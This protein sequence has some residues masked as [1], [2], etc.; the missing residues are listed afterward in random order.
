MQKC[1]ISSKRSISNKFYK[2]FAPI[3]ANGREAEA[4]CEV[5]LAYLYTGCPMKKLLSGATTHC[6]FRAGMRES[7][8]TSVVIDFALPQLRRSEGG[9]R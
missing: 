4:T 2:L 8:I 5:I 3:L 9:L 1:L 6:C 7:R